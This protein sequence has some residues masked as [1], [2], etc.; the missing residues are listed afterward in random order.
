MEIVNTNCTQAASRERC[1]HCP[2]DLK[3]DGRCTQARR[4][5]AST[6]TATTS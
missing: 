1:P 5:S 3:M 4:A 2:R 6:T